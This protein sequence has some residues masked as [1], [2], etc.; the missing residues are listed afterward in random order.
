MQLLLAC[1]NDDDGFGI[2][3]GNFPDAQQ[4]SQVLLNTTSHTGTHT[5]TLRQT[6]EYVC[7]CIC[8]SEYQMQH[9]RTRKYTHIKKQNKCRKLTR[10]CIWHNSKNLLLQFVE[11]HFQ[12]ALEY[13]VVDVVVADLTV[14]GNLLQKLSSQCAPL[15]QS[16]QRSS[17]VFKNFLCHKTSH[18]LRAPSRAQSRQDAR[19]ANRI[20]SKMFAEINETHWHLECR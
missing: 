14:C 17:T 15:P 20:S 9:E 5:P 8:M 12:F 7:R 6:R 11:F 2:I 18:K 3:Y 4:V 10:K 19:A 13:C 1:F 16:T